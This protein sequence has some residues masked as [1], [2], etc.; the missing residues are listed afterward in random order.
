MMV[1][2]LINLL[3]L[4]VRMNPASPATLL[5][6]ERLVAVGRGL[7][8]VRVSAG[9]DVPPPGTGFVTVT[10]IVPAVAIS[11]EVILA[12]TCVPSMSVVL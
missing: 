2:P 4:M 1:A 10:G 7:L 6:V 9:V 5:D 3:P 11:A 8:S 12:L